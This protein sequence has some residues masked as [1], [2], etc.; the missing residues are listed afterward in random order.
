MDDLDVPDLTMEQR[1]DWEAGFLGQSFVALGRAG[2]LVAILYHQTGEPWVGRL[3][4]DK[5]GY[6]DVAYELLEPETLQ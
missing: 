6:M 2:T 3:A 5:G 1:M 4:L